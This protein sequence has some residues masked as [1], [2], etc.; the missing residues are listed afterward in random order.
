MNIYEIVKSAVTTR[1]AAERYGLEVR[2]NGMALCPFHADRH[3]SLK[4][5]DRF[6]CFGCGATGDVIDFTSLLFHLSLYDA[7]CKLASDFGLN[8]TPPPAG[9]M[10]PR[11]VKLDPRQEERRCLDILLEY[12]VLLEDWRHR[13]FPVSPGALPDNRYVEACKMLALV[14]WLADE[15]STG[16]A[17]ERARAM[18]L[19]KRD[20]WI[21]RLRRYLR[22]VIDCEQIAS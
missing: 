3:P 8:N 21:D 5:D 17:D 1:Q 18:R 11:L 19:V 14:S 20:G 10:R 4:V 9:A 22:S 2:Y 16:Y 15:L 12:K 13:Y 7:A 6:Y